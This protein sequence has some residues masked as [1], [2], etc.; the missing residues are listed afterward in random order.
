MRNALVLRFDAYHPEE[1]L[2]EVEAL[3]RAGVMRTRLHLTHL[4]GLT[5]LPHAETLWA[6]FYLERR[7]EWRGPLAPDLVAGM[8]RH[9]PYFLHVQSRHYQDETVSDLSGYTRGVAGD[10]HLFYRLV[11]F[12]HAKIL[13]HGIDVMLF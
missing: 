11:R 5:Y 6:Y 12:L 1:P 10:T 2:L 7:A 13:E 9:L 8:E 3:E 4:A